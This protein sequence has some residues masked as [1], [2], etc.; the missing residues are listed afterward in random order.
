MNRIL[1]I[2]DKEG[3]SRFLQLEIEYEG[4]KTEKAYDGREVFIW[5]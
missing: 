3:I 5:H 1:I 2:E 4:Y